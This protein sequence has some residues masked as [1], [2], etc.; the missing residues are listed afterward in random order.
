MSWLIRVWC[1]AL[2]VLCG[3]GLTLGCQKPAPAPPL[4]A[5]PFLST[6]EIDVYVDHGVLT[7][8]LYLQNKSK[9]PLESIDMTLTIASEDREA[10]TVRH[11]GYWQ[12][13]ELK[14]LNIPAGRGR[15]QRVV[16]QGTAKVE[17]SGK[18]VG[19]KGEWLF[20]YDPKK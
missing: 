6:Q 18:P 15:V 5:M 10:S 8:D 4:P 16:I 7:H 9:L 13:D 11:W 2:T 17:T 20:K 1:C 12:E 3:L 19:I 14:T